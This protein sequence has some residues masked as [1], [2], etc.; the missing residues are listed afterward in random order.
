MKKV[1]PSVKIE[2]EAHITLNEVEARALHALTVYGEKS[3]LNVFY[4]K[5]GTPYL[6]PHEEGLISLFKAIKVIYLPSSKP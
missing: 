6:K 1:H 3:F 2:F 5:L 4:E